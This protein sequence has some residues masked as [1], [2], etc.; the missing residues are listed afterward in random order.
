MNV[1]IVSAQAILHGRFSILWHGD[2]GREDLGLEGDAFKWLAFR[3]EH[4][5][6]VNELLFRY[7]NRVDE[8]DGDRLRDADFELPSL[9]VGDLIHWGSKTW[10]VAG[11]G[12]EL[13][14][15]SSEYAMAL[16]ALTLGPLS[17]PEGGG[18]G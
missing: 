2:V 5:E 13:L 8:A 3:E 12:F 16:T 1:Q 6:R 14:T 15:G 10:R 11:S 18:E 7:F 17:G 9:S 4:P